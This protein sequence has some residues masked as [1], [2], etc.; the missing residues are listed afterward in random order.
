MEKVIVK[1]K[2]KRRNSNWHDI[3]KSLNPAP[4]E[5]KRNFGISYNGSRSERKY[6]HFT[7]LLNFSLDFNFSDTI[8]HIHVFLPCEF[9]L[10]IFN[11]WIWV[12]RRSSN[13][14]ITSQIL[15]S[16]SQMP[17]WSNPSGSAEVYVT[18]TENR[19]TCMYTAKRQM[20]SPF[21]EH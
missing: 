2:N 20:P 18:A 16:H 11:L 17:T 10:F 4:S 19:H 8:S 13:M 12:L 21:S 5:S 1:I 15:F 14:K 3:N 9:T 6:L 7:T